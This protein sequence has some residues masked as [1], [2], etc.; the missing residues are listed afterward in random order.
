MGLASTCGE[1][2]GIV[3]RYLGL[4][5]VGWICFESLLGVARSCW[6]L[7]GVDIIL[8]TALSCR[9]LLELA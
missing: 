5:R 9:E 6:E 3:G 2:C 4:L 1:L 7:L 8:G